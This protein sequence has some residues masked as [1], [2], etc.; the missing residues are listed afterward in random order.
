[1]FDF[2]LYELENLLAQDAPFLDNTS[3]GLDIKT[4]TRLSFFPKN[5]DIILCG[6]DECVKLAKLQGL[7][8]EFSKENAN[9]IKAKETFLS[10]KGE[11]QIVLKVAKSFQNILEY[12]SS[13]ATYTNKM[14]NLARK[15]NDKIALLGTRKTMPFA[16]KLLLKALISGGGLPHRYGLSDS[17]LIF[18]EHKLLCENLQND[19]INLKTKF[20]EHKI[21][22]EISSIEESIKFAKMGADILQCERFCVNDLKTIK[23]IRDEEFP[24]ILLSATGNINLENVSEFARTGVDIIVSTAMY[25]AK[26]CD[27]KLSYERL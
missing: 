21:I 9:F 17:I 4:D 5:D 15:E 10:I 6:I 22:V 14:L 25:R 2:S 11:A 26:I 24:N 27:I 23:K 16:K 19:F 18:D 3:F 20:K 1:M 12:T 13:V 7:E 8:V